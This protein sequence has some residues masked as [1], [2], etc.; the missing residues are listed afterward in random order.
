[1]IGLSFRVPPLALISEPARRWFGATVVCA[2]LF[3]LAGCATQAPPVQKP[4][5]ESPSLS[6][7]VRHG[8]FAMRT[9]A[10]HEEPEAV[11]GGFVWRDAGGRLTL[12]L[13]N[14]FGSTMARVLV[15]PG[16]ATMTQSNGE[17]LSSSDPDALVQQVIGR[18][19]PVRNMRAWLR[20]SLRQSP[21]MQQVRHDEQGRI[22]A[23]AESGWKV[24]LGR[25]DT[26]G[27]RLLVLSR[28]EG[29]KQ[30]V[31]RLVVDAH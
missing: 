17:T 2:L 22:V 29:R 16:Q 30:V 27:P 28:L 11:Q 14:P 20:A 18:R 31:I 13:I 4:L 8:R 26:L 1:M 7:F 10:P 24:E 5:T 9:E 21:G 15:E 25:F 6:E 23:F 19:V 3:V 12:D